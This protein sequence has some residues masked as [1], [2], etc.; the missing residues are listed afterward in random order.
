MIAMLRAA[1]VSNAN[2]LPPVP[3]LPPSAMHFA[4]NLF[5]WYGHGIPSET[6]ARVQ[7]FSSPTCCL[8]I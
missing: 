4:S 2:L 6:E 3:V 5:T 1:S 7:S 8:S